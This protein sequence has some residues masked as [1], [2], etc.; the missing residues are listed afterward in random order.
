[1]EDLL[2]IDERLDAV[3]STLPNGAAAEVAVDPD[4]VADATLFDVAYSPW[5]TPLAAAWT[6]E[7]VIGGLEMLVLQA[8]AQVR[9]FVHGD[10][11]L[12]LDRDEEVLAAM[13]SAV[14]L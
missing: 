7:S 3:I 1:L 5:P 12:K 6:G 8:L 2:Q 10:P 9:I 11:D 14:D 4:T 13:R